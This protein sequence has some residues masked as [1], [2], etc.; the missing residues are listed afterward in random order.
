MTS[1]YHETD[2]QNGYGRSSRAPFT[3]SADLYDN[4]GHGEDTTTRRGRVS[5]FDVYLLH[6]GLHESL[7]ETIDI[8][9]SE[10][11]D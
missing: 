5:V 6:C 1:A 9:A 4:L 10:V 8:T 7:H 2:E 11:S 3:Y